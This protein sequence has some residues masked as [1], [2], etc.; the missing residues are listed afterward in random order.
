MGCFYAR[1]GRD[2]EALH[3][4]KHSFDLNPELKKIARTDTDLVRI[5]NHADFVALIGS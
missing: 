2:D 4:L 3:W 5:R 1:V